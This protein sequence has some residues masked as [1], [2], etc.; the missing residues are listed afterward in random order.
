MKMQ[1]VELADGRRVARVRRAI[2]RMNAGPRVMDEVKVFEVEPD[3]VVDSE[4]EGP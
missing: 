1:I 2:D 3:P 4:T